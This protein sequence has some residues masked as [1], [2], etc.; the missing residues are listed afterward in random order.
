MLPTKNAKPFS[1][2]VIYPLNSLYPAKVVAH[3]LVLFSVQSFSCVLALFVNTLGNV[4]DQILM[5]VI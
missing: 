1:F 5:A 2:I 4:S 3:Q